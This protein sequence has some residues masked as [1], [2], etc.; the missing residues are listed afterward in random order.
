MSTVRKFRVKTRLSTMALRNGG[1]TAQEAIKRADSALEELKPPSKADIDAAIAELEAR[2][3]GSRPEAG[4]A[5]AELL[6]A[7]SARIIDVSFC[8]PNSGIDRAARALCDLVDLSMERGVWDQ[9]AVDVHIEALR[10]LR[11]MGENVAAAQREAVLS[12]LDR[13]LKKRVAGTS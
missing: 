5:H 6:Y 4:G 8:L 10:M 1:I 12:G 11:L 13:V 3:V 2:F 7:V 9:Q